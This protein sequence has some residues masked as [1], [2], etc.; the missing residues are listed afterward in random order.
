AGKP[1]AQPAAEPAAPPAEIVALAGRP[2]APEVA[3]ATP[4][5]AEKAVEAATPAPVPAGKPAD[6]GTNLVW[7]AG[8]ALFLAG[9]AWLL[10]RRSSGGALATGGAAA[11]PTATRPAQPAPPQRRITDPELEN[12]AE[13]RLDI[14]QAC[15]DL[16]RYDAAR[17]ELERV[18]QDGNAEQRDMAQQM[19]MM[20][21]ARAA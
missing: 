7:V 18:S 2:T 14:A 13:I 3:K 9:G 12:D 4:A 16:E 1:A 15:M 11:E 6:T 20:L 19:L 5:E 10:L 8:A 21:P 17:A